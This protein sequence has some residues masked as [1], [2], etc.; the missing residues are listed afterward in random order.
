MLAGGAAAL[1]L[2]AC[3]GAQAAAPVTSTVTVTGPAS[4]VTATQT[5]TV[6][7][8]PMT[9]TISETATTTAIATRIV[10]RTTTLV[11]VSTP[12]TVADGTKDV[13]LGQTVDLQL[14]KVTALTV[15]RHV[16][17][18]VA[19]DYA[20]VEVRVCIENQPKGT[21]LSWG[22]W[23][24]SSSDGGQY[25]ALSTDYSSDIPKPSYPFFGRQLMMNG[26][27]AQGWIAFG[28]PADNSLSLVR[29]ATTDDNNNLLAARWVIKP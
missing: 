28:A 6:S 14:A 11:P 4:T 3:G 29:Y 19:G 10:Q 1:V 20:A 13:P 23:A 27:C 21:T 12:V 16:K 18:A 26:D 8:A 5:A 9:A 7:A 2:T 17:L 25:P 24:L 15:Q 22:P